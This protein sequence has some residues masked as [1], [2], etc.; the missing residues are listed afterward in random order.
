MTSNTNCEY[1]KDTEYVSSTKDENLKQ[2]EYDLT[3]EDIEFKPT[4]DFPGGKIL[5]QKSSYRTISKN[6]KKQKWSPLVFDGRE[7]GFSNQGNTENRR[8]AFD[9]FS[10]KKSLDEKLKKT[11]MCNSV[12]GKIP[13]ACKHGPNCRFAHTTDELQISTCF[14][15]DRCLYVA[16]NDSGNIINCGKKIC[17][18][19]H[20]H[21]SKDQ[22][23]LRTGL[24][25]AN[26]TTPKVS[27]KQEKN[28]VVHFTPTKSNFKLPRN[29]NWGEM[30]VP[31]IFS[32]TEKQEK[33]DRLEVIVETEKQEKNDTSEETVIRVPKS[34]AVSAL[35]LAIKMGKTSIKI[36]IV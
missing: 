34:M 12:S 3:H 23:L 26:H 13:I 21:E 15:G 10:N 14:F 22:F 31:P 11:R 7:K 16:F 1:V 4:S 2:V 5:K 20:P 25:K 36:V 27:L 24:S 35:E 32:K 6:G 18:H 17:H 28:V 33:N 9:I 30:N 19:K 8:Q 29:S